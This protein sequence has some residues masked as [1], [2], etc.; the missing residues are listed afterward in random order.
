MRYVLQYKDIK[1]EVV[2][3][4]P[5]VAFFDVAAV[6]RAGARVWRDEDEWPS[7][8]RVETPRP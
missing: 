3:T 6:E 2:A 5:S 7:E 8:V 1:V 4:K